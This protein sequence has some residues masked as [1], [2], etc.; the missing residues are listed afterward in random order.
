MLGKKNFRA[1]ITDRGAA[2]YPSLLE[3]SCRRSFLRVLGGGLLAAAVGRTVMGC[4]DSLFV[5]AGVPDM[6]H[7]PF[8]AAVEQ[9]ADGWF[10]HD[11]AGLPD[12]GHD[13]MPLDQLPPQDLPSTAECGGLDAKT[14]QDGW[15]VH[16]SAGTPDMGQ[17]MTPQDS[18]TQDSSIKDSATKESGNATDAGER[19]DLVV[20]KP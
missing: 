9:P 13:V 17:D 7:A 6:M 18:S 12:M 8:D 10:L 14:Q 5:T 16:D 11:T 3:D 19:L 1:S 2:A 15:F 20:I 4:D